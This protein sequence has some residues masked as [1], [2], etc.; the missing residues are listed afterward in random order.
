M[1]SFSISAAFL[2][3]TF[4]F[5][6]SFFSTTIAAFDETLLDPFTVDVFDRTVLVLS[7]DD[8]CACYVTR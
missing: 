5:G 1:E 6:S 8:S 7:E 2:L 3:A 4:S